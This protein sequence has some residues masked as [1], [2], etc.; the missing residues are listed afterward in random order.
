MELNLYGC[1]RQFLES[2]MIKYK[3]SLKSLATTSNNVV[4]VSTLSRIIKKNREGE[5]LK[6]FDISLD[7]WAQ[8]IANL[9]LTKEQALQALLLR[10][11]DEIADLKTPLIKEVS[12]LLDKV[13]G[14]ISSESIDESNLSKEALYIADT[15]DKLPARF[16]K[17]IATES[18]KVIGFLDAL[19]PAVAQTLDSNR[20]MMRRIID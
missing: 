18:F 13:H 19:N 4:S 10:L 9:R 17:S 2:Y 11:K 14:Q 20:K 3:L 7:S 8:L 15:Y 1:H 5:F 16:Q 6:A 12:K